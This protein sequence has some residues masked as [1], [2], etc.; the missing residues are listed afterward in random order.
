M[1]QFDADT[2]FVVPVRTDR[3]DEQITVRYPSEEQWTAWTR[4]KSTIVT[5]LGRGESQWE[6]ERNEADAQLYNEIRCEGQPDLDNDEAATLIGIL[7]KFE[8]RGVE[9][10]GNN[11]LEIRAG[12]MGGQVTHRLKIPTAKQVAEL[13]RHR[14]QIVSMPFNRQRIR[15]VLPPYVALWDKTKVVVEGYVNGSIPAIHKE[16]A[17]RAVLEYIGTEADDPNP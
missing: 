9:S 12:V 14:S 1:P 17:I 13:N 2:D 15:T 5:M 16:S 4:K 10:E 6:P 7:S 11:E 3:G 8:V